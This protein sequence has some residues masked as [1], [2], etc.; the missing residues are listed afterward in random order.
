MDS[1]NDTNCL[2]PETLIHIGELEKDLKT[3]KKITLNPFRKI[4]AAI[5]LDIILPQI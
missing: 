3:I 5:L 2:N 1:A 4:A